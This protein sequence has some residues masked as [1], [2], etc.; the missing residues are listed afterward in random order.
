[1][2]TLRVLVVMMMVAPS[3]PPSPSCPPPL[4]APP[5]ALGP[6][7]LPAAGSVLLWCLFTSLLLLAALRAYHL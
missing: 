1:M 2:M 7:L 4:Q 5:A 6:A 3:W